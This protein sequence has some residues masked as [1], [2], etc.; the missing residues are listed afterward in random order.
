MAEIKDSLQMAEI[1]DSL[2]MAVISWQKKI[3]R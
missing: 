2:Q 1:K 3:K